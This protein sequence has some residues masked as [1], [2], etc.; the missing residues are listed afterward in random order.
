MSAYKSAAGSVAGIIGTIFVSAFTLLV[1]Q[2]E[3]TLKLMSAGANEADA[4]NIMSE[5]VSAPS[6]LDQLNIY[7]T[8]SDSYPVETLHQESIIAG[9]RVNTAVG[10]LG[11]LAA[12][13]IIWRLMRHQA[14]TK[15]T[16]MAEVESEN[17]ELDS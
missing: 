17:A 10:L 5:I 14:M 16:S 13:L 1:I 11:T 4:S 6:S 12:A 2:Y 8:Y 7:P 3:L 9:F 15:M